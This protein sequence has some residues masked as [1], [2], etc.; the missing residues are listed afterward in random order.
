LYRIP[1][2]LYDGAPWDFVFVW[3]PSTIPIA[4]ITIL[5]TMIL[6]MF[7]YSVITVFEKPGENPLFIC[8]LLG[9]VSGIGNAIII[10]II[11]FALSLNPNQDSNANTLFNLLLFFILGILIYIVGQ[12][13]TRIKLIRFING[14]VY[15]K[16]LEL[17]NK[18][19]KTPYQEIE[20]FQSGKI[21]AVLNNDTEAISGYINSIVGALISSITVICSFIYLGVLDLKVLAL[22]IGVVLIAAG[23]YFIA[24]R[25]SHKIWEQ[26][27]DIQNTFFNFINDML[28]GFKELYLNLKKQGEFKEDMLSS[29]NSYRKKRIKADTN[30]ANVFILG[31]L[32][33]TLVIGIIALVYPRIFEDVEM[34]TLRNY[35]FV[36]LYIT[37]P[38]NIILFAIPNAIQF[39][40]SL[41]RIGE[42]TNELAQIETDNVEIDRCEYSREQFE[43]S[44]SNITFKY[45]NENGDEF[46]VGPIDYAF[47]SSEIIFITGGN[48]SGKSTLAKLITGIYTPEE[49]IVTING[50]NVTNSTLR[51]QFSAIFS[52]FHLFDKLYGIDFEG[53][54][55]LIQQYLQI[56]HLE[57][58]VKVNAGKFSSTKL[59][60]GQRK[61]LALMI[62]YLEDKPVCLFD[63]WAADQDPEFR[64]YFYSVLLPELKKK[65]K[66]VI[67]ITHDDRYFNLA[68][69]VIK[70]E[71]GKIVE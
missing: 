42:V 31:E 5:L 14:F 34:S 48:G 39:R 38:I 40:I 60:T 18:I 50:K 16:R 24:G 46:K 19:L 32:V 36:F 28:T 41:K 64:M 67:A 12:R 65:N 68:D 23:L 6:L 15:N 49:G 70:M 33:F 53:K 3:G 26:T 4:I 30:M 11:N 29:C 55:E 21:F 61:R 56:L 25:I 52:D 37:G 69:K 20:K 10:F 58:K 8:I 27:R 7:Y 44:L 63:E 57:D 71:M 13:L 9:A 35:V 66:C 62:S 43:L 47:K 45:T 51:Q 17:I 2:L 54:A 22:S 59:S 1:K